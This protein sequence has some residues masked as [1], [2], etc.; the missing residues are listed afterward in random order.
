[1]P[2]FPERLRRASGQPFAAV[3][4]LAF[5]R[6]YTTAEG[7]AA[8]EEKTSR[9]NAWPSERLDELPKKEWTMN[10]TKS[11]GHPLDRLFRPSSIVLVGASDKSRW[12]RMAIRNLEALGFQGK[13]HVVNRRPGEVLG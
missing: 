8:A 1:M 11:H 9:R 5:L 4:G 7:T 13:L 2:T 10:E 3:E 12:A 6:L